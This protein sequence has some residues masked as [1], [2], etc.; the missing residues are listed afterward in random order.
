MNRILKAQIEDS[1]QELRRYVSDLQ[2]ALRDIRAAILDNRPH[3]LWLNPDERAIDR[4]G[5]LID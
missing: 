1:P 3:E 5:H 4:I 2:K